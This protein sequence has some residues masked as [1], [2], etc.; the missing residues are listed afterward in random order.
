LW[1]NPYQTD[2]IVLR[3]TQS[4]LTK[5]FYYNNLN[6]DLLSYY[7]CHLQVLIAFLVANALA[8]LRIDF[9]EYSNLDWGQ[10]SYYVCHLQAFI[11]CLVANALAY[12]RRYLIE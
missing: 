2:L 11:G 8:Y 4:L 9:I 6:R 10:I 7:V 5:T 3:R 12:L 1:S